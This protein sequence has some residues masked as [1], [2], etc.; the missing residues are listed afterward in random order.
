M[1]KIK[2]FGAFLAVALLV[3]NFAG[4]S[5]TT[6][7]PEETENPT[8]QT[9]KEFAVSFLIDGKNIS[10][11]YTVENETAKKLSF[12][13][14]DSESGSTEGLPA[15]SA[16]WEIK[17]G[18]KYLSLDA[19]E[20]TEIHITNTNYSD[21]VQPVMLSLAVTP[22]SETYKSAAATIKL[23]V[24]NLA[25]KDIAATILYDGETVSETP[26]LKSIQ[27]VLLSYSLAPLNANEIGATAKWEFESGSEYVAGSNSY[28][29]LKI[30]NMNCSGENQEVTVKLT[31]TPNNPAY[32]PASASFTFIAED[33]TEDIQ[34]GDFTA[35][36]E[37]NETD[38]TVKISWT[39]SKNAQS[40]Y[41]YRKDNNSRFENYEEIACVTDEL[42]Y[43][44]GDYDSALPLE[45]NK[46][47]LTYYVKAVNHNEVA[48]LDF[49][50]KTNSVAVDIASVIPSKPAEINGCAKKDRWGYWY[51]DFSW[52]LED[53]SSGAKVYRFV[54]NPDSYLWGQPGF[55]EIIA[56]GSLIAELNNSDIQN[57]NDYYFLDEINTDAHYV[58]YAIMANK[59]YNTTVPVAVA[60][61]PVV[62]YL[63]CSSL[64]GK[65]NKYTE[66]ESGSLGGGSSSSGSVSISASKHIESNY[67]GWCQ[68]D[69][70]VK[71]SGVNVK[72]Y[73]I[74]R[75]ARRSNNWGTPSKADFSL[76]GSQTYSPYLDFIYLNGFKYKWENTSSSGKY[77]YYMYYYVEAVCSDG[78]VYTSEIVKAD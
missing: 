29:S 16:K 14:S 57:V 53:N 26:H 3:L 46:T 11:G 76:I 2:C 77:Y 35:S 43:L 58:Y 23:N 51:I 38:G 33:S 65:P 40:Y 8:T 21:S 70:A 18:S 45:K 74:Y 30:S 39:A 20:G 64:V 67:Y 61:E 25:K 56:K 69:F 49:S 50:C 68:I 12:S 72:E 55:K 27:D 32:N 17:S 1:G 10:E 6:D 4:C 5:G 19:S 78:K 7:S 15:V 13:Y 28:S 62:I 63:D 44:D 41:V 42:Y 75:C 73:K 36:A 71:T 37:L 24:S 47:S 48:N 59:T 66:Q 22:K 54:T 60:S 52:K 31:L 9:Q 34:P